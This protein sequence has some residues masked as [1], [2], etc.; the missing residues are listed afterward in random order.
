MSSKATLTVPDVSKI[1]VRIVLDWT[2]E[3]CIEVI[4]ELSSLKDGWR[5]AIQLYDTLFALVDDAAK[6]IEGIEVKK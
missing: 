1:R 6:L 4:N 5:P 2:I 3:E